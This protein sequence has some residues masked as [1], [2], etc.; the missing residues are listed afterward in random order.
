[1]QSADILPCA[2]RRAV[3]V[4]VN[5]RIDTLKIETEVPQPHTEAKASGPGDS[6]AKGS[7]LQ[8][9]LGTSVAK[10]RIDEQHEVDR[11]QAEAKAADDISPRTWWKLN[12]HRCPHMQ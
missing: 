4:E 10:E 8:F 1:M 7:A 6:S 9:L 11:Y 5:S 3:W 12:G 2:L